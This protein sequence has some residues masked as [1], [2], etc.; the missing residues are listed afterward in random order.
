MNHSSNNHQHIDSERQTSN[1]RPTTRSILM[2]AHTSPIKELTRTTIIYIP[3]DTR[4]FPQPRKTPIQEQ[5][6]ICYSICA[7]SLPKLLA[8]ALPHQT[9][10]HRPFNTPFSTRIYFSIFHPH[11]PPQTLHIDPSQSH[12]S[13]LKSA[14]TP[15]PRNIPTPQQTRN[16]NRTLKPPLSHLHLQ[17]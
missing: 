5:D 13:D 15:N 7:T 11:L 3:K 6:A 14:P 16:P 12:S 9:T 10:T 4:D 17:P 1:Y 2:K 8:L